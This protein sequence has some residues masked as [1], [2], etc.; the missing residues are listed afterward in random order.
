MIFIIKGLILIK[1]TSIG[2]YAFRG[3]TSLT[4]INYQ[5]TKSEW[6]NV[7]SV[8]LGWSNGSSI[9]TITCTDGQITI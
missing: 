5:G 7:S 9:K 1:N 3:C 6:N 4:N 2:N 8:S